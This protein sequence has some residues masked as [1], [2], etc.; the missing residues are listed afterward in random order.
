MF[1]LKQLVDWIT[2]KPSRIFG[3]PY[4]QLNIGSTADLVL[5]NLEESQT[6]EPDQFASKGRNTPFVNWEV[7]G[8]PVM[9]ILE[10]EIVW[11]KD[12]LYV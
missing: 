7:Q 2:I 8:I 3:L 6:I 10:G 5:V 4:G 9:T 12:E 1:S 11:R